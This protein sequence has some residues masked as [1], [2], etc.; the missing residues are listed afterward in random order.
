MRDLMTTHEVADYLR[1]KERKVYDL[2]ANHRIPCTRATGK[3]LFPRAVIDHWLLSS[4][5][6][7]GGPAPVDTPP[8]VGGSHDP[9]LG[10]SIRESGSELAILFDG[11]LDGVQRVFDH[12]VRACGMHVI[13]AAT[14]GYNTHLVEPAPGHSALVLIEWA[15]R[16]Q[17]LIVATGNPLRIHS[18]ADVAATHARVIDRQQSAGSHLLLNHLLASLGLTSDALNR[19]AGP[20]RNESDAALA[21]AD[22]AA[23]AA[24]GIAAVARQ[25]R[26]DFVPLQRERYDLLMQRRDYFEPPLQALFRFARTAA[27]AEKAEALGGYDISGLGRVRYN[28]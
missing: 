25:Y 28:G 15:F 20:A 26:L 3:W 24:L 14:G 23:D 12:R 18:V 5:E 4:T 17:G 9:L 11:S 22:G 7:G 10:W 1:I 21:V 19:I 6:L 13:D 27:F 16:D 8:V 2:V